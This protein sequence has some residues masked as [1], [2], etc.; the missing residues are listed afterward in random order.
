MF[1]GLGGTSSTNGSG[2]C[3]NVSPSISLGAG[4][5]PPASH[6]QKSKGT[7]TDDLHQLVDN[8]ARDAI[9]LSQCK[10]GPKTGAPAAIGHDVSIK[11]K[12]KPVT[13]LFLCLIFL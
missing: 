10:K 5:A 3:Q 4:H 6:T 7:F 13:T 1:Q 9:S 12:K 8:W 11:N 2:Y